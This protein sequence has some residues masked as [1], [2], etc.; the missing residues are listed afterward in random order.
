MWS[1]DYG[2]KARKDAQKTRD[3]YY[4]ELAGFLAIIG[5]AFGFVYV[6]TWFIAIYG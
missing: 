6:M 3:H 4:D 5:A 1:T 2:E